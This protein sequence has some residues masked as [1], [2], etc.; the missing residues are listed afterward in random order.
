MNCRYLNASALL[1]FPRTYVPA[2]RLF[3]AAILLSFSLSVVAVEVAAV[4]ETVR[5]AY[6]QFQPY[7]YQD[8]DGNPAGSF[9]EAT[10]KVAEEAG[11][12]VKFI[13]LPVSRAYLY[14][15]NGKVDAWAGM[16]HTPALL[17]KV[18]ESEISPV[19][20]HLSAWYR[21]DTEVLENF[22][23][24]KG[25]T[26]IIIG[27]YTYGGLIDWLHTT[28]G[29]DVT[30]APNH[31]SAIE[32]LKRKRGDYLLDYLEPVQQILTQPSDS[33]IRESAIRTRP[34]A[35]IF[36]LK[37]PHAALFREDFDSAYLRLMKA[38]KMPQVN[39]LESSFV[40]PGFPE[41]YR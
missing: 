6:A 40:I 36:S 41:Q 30:E 3:M 28:G 17:N 24:L 29:I 12:H 26:V 31:R 16:K 18:L 23:Q 19:S 8:N 7:T 22:E 37:S 25:K 33:I 21:S 1:Y 11:Y 5:M 2:V 10:R 9:I 14:L 27:G 4:P 20:A 39:E 34:T 35:W 13:L 32:M 15:V 38:G